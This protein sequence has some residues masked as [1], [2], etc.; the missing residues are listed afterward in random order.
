MKASTKTIRMAS[1]ST[2]SNCT[3]STR[4]YRSSNGL[5]H[6][7]GYGKLIS[8]SRISQVYMQSLRGG[9]TL[10]N[11]T[12]EA[13]SA[14]KTKTPG[15]IFLDNLGTVFLSA[16]AFVIL[17]L[18]RSS[19]GTTN[20]NNLRALIENTAALDP[21]EVDDLRTANDQFTPEIYRNIYKAMK[22][23]HGW[24]LDQ[25][26]DYKLFV[27][28]VIQEM[29]GMKGEAFTIQFGHLLDRVI[30]SIINKIGKDEVQYSQIEDEKEWL[31]VRLLLVALSLAMNGSVRERVEALYDILVE[32][33]EIQGQN[34]S[35]GDETDFPNRNDS[36]NGSI[37]KEKDI[38]KMVDYLQKTCQLVPDGQMIESDTKY[39]FQEYIVGSPAELTAHG[40][41]LKKEDIS[42][43]A[44]EGGEKGWSCDDFHHLLKS[45]SV[46]AW[47]ECYVKKKS[48]M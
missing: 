47:G 32:D 1:P 12:T 30:V 19:R 22:D 6:G 45:K 20:K 16:I 31:E 28:A 40:K 8:M 10:R 24:Q 46:C 5:G 9:N 38:V 42:E 7:H 26:I 48:L 17:T 2:S 3:A 33:D 15:D 36:M 34:G 37:V 39:P 41:V 35:E 27:S 44:L 13:A 14:K 43:E 23:K 25:K 29:K 21:F 4:C 11:L 18:V